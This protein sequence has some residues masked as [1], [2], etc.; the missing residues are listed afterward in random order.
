MIKL[1]GLA[2]SPEEAIMPREVFLLQ[3]SSI[4]SLWYHILYYFMNGR[5]GM[6]VYF[7]RSN[8]F[9]FRVIPGTLCG[10]SF[11]SHCNHLSYIIFF[12]MVPCIISRFCNVKN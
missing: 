5:S 4:I 11:I 10:F 9:F 2:H 7:S 8:K 3:V 12:M 1:E 6:H